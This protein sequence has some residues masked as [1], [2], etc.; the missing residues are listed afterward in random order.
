[1]HLSIRVILCSVYCAVLF[2]IL[3]CSELDT[4]VGLDVDC[5]METMTSVVLTD[6]GVPVKAL[7]FLLVL[8]TFF[9]IFSAN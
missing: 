4:V 7:F 9:F 6:G 2:L 8:D 5:T 1:M 3:R